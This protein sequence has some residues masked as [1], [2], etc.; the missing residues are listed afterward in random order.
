M[1]RKAPY[2]RESSPGVRMGR[3]GAAE[4]E[5]SLAPRES[6]GTVLRRAREHYGEDLRSV[7]QSLRIRYVY[8]LCIEEGRFA[9]LPGPT[10]AVGFVRTYAEY[11]GLDGV[12]MVNRFKEEVDNVDQKQELV[13]PTPSPES[14]VPGGALILISVMLV[15]LAY[16]GWFYLSSQGKSIADL[17]PPVPERLAALIE[18]EDTTGT[19]EGEAAQAGESTASETSPSGRP[20]T[21]VAAEP[22][23][24]ESL[25]GQGDTLAPAVAAPRPEIA[26][27]TAVNGDALSRSAATD[28]VRRTGLTASESGTG[29]LVG[30]SGRPALPTETTQTAPVAPAAAATGSGDFPTGASDTQ[31]A[32]V[33]EPAAA[34]GEPT[35]PA[36]EQA[37]VTLARVLDAGS[38]PA[39]TAPR[40]AEIED[41]AIPAAPSTT[42]V[43]VAGGREPQVYGADND[44]ARIVLRAR[45]DSWVQVRDSD[46]GLLIT[47]V[48]RSGD[49]YRVPNRPGLTLLTGNAGGIEIEVDGA[50]LSPIGPIGAVRRDVVL[51]PDQLKRGTTP[52]R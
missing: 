17:V 14:R 42:Q 16:G 1:A 28:V 50:R 31:S 36:D 44:D 39:G 34:A 21:P 33:A 47:R 30:S 9:D 48:L 20:E 8:L 5:P 7:A 51:D 49:V 19:G 35:N 27:S 52:E 46:D 6:V 40:A 38:Q 13:F 15:A 11:L 24:V 41:S 43:A 23:M 26:A 3:L 2:A 37:A 10:Y 12:E 22:A 4:P 32:P 29:E 45:Q 25:P 18:G